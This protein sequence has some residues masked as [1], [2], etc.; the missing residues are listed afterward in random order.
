MSLTSNAYWWLFDQVNVTIDLREDDLPFAGRREGSRQG[1][2]REC[3]GVGLP[4][5]VLIGD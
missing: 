5:S 4:V 2:R 1:L 3:G